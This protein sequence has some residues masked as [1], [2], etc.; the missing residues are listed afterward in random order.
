MNIFNNLIMSNNNMMNL[1]KILCS[2][3]HEKVKKFNK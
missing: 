1:D 2:P 3:F